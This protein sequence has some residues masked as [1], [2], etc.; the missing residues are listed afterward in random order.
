MRD[1]FNTYYLLYIICEAV[2]E[3]KNSST[4]VRRFCQWNFNK[5]EISGILIWVLDNLIV[6]FQ[7]NNAMILFL[8]TRTIEANSTPNTL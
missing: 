2:S 3:Y 5:R 6:N 7:I 4:I 8:V 1:S